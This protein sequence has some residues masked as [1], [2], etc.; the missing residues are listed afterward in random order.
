[1]ANRPAPALALREGDR[2]ELERLTRS[3]R[4][5]DLHRRLERPSP[6][7]HLDQ[8]RRPDPHQGQAS[9]VFKHGALADVMLGLSAPCFSAGIGGAVAALVVRFRRSRGIERQQLK[10]FTYAAAL[11]PLPSWLMSWHAAPGRCC[12][13]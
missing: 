3:S 9:T 7:L 6:P 4:D 8:D 2:V 5:P 11:A 13:R 12:W 1:V 10:W